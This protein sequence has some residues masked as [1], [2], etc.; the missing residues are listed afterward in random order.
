MTKI[1]KDQRNALIKAYAKYLAKIAAIFAVV[2]LISAAI[3]VYYFGYLS[4]RHVEVFRTQQ[5]IYTFHNSTMSYFYKSTCYVYNST[6]FHNSTGWYDS[7][8]YYYTWTTTDM[9]NDADYNSTQVFY[10]GISTNF[11]G[12]YLVFKETIPNS[13]QYFPIES[14]GD[15]RTSDKMPTYPGPV[16]ANTTFFTT[17]GDITITYYFNL[18]LTSFTIRDRTFKIEQIGFAED[19]SAIKL[20]W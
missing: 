8:Y 15:Y 17:P 3:T 10:A 1:S 20:S 7:D 11:T 13:W 18:D 12:S 4:P 19:T 6:Q 5:Q 9:I 2:A 16:S 14:E